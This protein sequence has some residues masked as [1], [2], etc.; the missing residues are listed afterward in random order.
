MAGQPAVHFGQDAAALTWVGAAPAKAR[1]DGPMSWTGM[2]ALIAVAAAVL[3]G[4]LYAAYRRRA[5]GGTVALVLAAVILLGAS[6]VFFYPAGL[7][8]AD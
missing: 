6:V 1:Y 2:I 5:L 4:L 8:I 7:I 3:L